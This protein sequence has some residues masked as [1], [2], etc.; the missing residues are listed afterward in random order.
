MGISAVGIQKG[1]AIMNEQGK[2]VEH[3][4]FRDGVSQ[5]LIKG[6]DD[7]EESDE[8]FEPSDFVLAGPSFGWAN[9]G[10]FWCTEGYD[11]M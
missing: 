6:I 1:T 5:P 9:E 11:R 4:G 3:F 7:V 10:S 8:I 2:N